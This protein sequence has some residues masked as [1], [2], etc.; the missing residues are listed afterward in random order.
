MP[1]EERVKQV[2]YDLTMKEKELSK[3][4][5]ELSKIGSFLEKLGSDLVRSPECV[6]FGRQAVPLRF[7][8]VKSVSLPINAFSEDYLKQKTGKIRELI[9]A[10][11]DLKREKKDLGL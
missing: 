3:E 11:E 10:I 8:S 1:D 5:K 7:H 6:I 2:L 9:E 4:R